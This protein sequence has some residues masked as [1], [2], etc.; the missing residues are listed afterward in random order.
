MTVDDDPMV[1]LE[2][3]EFGLHITVSRAKK[4]FGEEKAD[5]SARLEVKQFIDYEVF[6]FQDPGGLMAEE[7]KSAI[8]SSMFLREKYFPDGR[9]EKL[10]ARLVA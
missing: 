4:L 8:W 10:K 7:V 3:D 6:E 9:F 1:G 2:A 5:E